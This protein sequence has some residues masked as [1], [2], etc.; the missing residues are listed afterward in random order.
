MY[1]QRLG[2]KYVETNK[3]REIIDGGLILCGGSDSDVCDYNPFVG[4]HSAVNHPVKKHR[5]S[6]YEAIKMY[7]LN[8][9]YAIFEENNKGSLEIGKLADIIILDTD[10]FKIDTENIDKVK[11]LC[12]I[13]SGKILYN[14]I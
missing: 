13:K 6:L 8:G 11:V 7:T 2:K 4:I 9:A 3:F 14:V 12:T 5:I 10:I 1:S